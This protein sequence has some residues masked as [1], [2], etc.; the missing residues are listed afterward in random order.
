MEQLIEI[1]RRGGNLPVHYPEDAEVYLRAG[2][3]ADGTLF[4]AVFN[5][6]LD[7]LEDVPLS[8]DFRVSRVEMLNAEGERE[9]VPYSYDA[10]GTLRVGVP[11]GI[12]SPVI[13]FL[14]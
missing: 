1:L 5:I 4:C 14:S 9:R 13:L 12:L 2:Y 6:G 10:D 11:A 8:V 3:L 7:P